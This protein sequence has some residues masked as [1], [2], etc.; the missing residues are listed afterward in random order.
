ML[1]G[2]W[3]DVGSEAGPAP[4]RPAWELRP[5]PLTQAAI[6]LLA[7]R[8]PPD[9][10]LPL[11]EAVSH[12]SP[13]WPHFQP[14]PQGPK[15]AQCGMGSQRL[16]PGPSEKSLPPTS[17]NG[18]RGGR[19]LWLWPLLTR[20]SFCPSFFPKGDAGQERLRATAAAASPAQAAFLLLGLR[21][22]RDWNSHPPPLGCWP[23][24]QS[25]CTAACGHS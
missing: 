23:W 6:V 2:C 13:A 22:P 21:G 1:P 25:H 19:A 3:E 12:S 8:G 10:Q 20:N 9:T 7:G 17:S 11:L 4:L 5:Q 15:G 24:S 16:F 18:G 14:S